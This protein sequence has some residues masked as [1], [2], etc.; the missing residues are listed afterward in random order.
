MKNQVEAGN[1]VVLHLTGKTEND[2]VF[3]TTRGEQPLEFTIGEGKV[4][5]GVENGVLGMQIGESR[6]LTVPPEDAFGVRRAELVSTV[7]K[8]DFP[9]SIRPSVGQKLQI[10]TEDD[11]PT[12]VRV[13][14]IEADDVT[15]DANHPLAGQTLK[16]EIDLLA[17]Q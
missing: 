13:T 17:I 9:D 12:E 1:H 5:P 11:Q 7:K 8:E 16:F 2:E 4:I 15:L 3:A 14:K 10:K 6:I